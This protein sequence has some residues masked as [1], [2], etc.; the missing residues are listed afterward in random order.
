MQYTSDKFK[1]HYL[2]RYTLLIK[3]GDVHDVL[4][5]LDDQQ[6]ILRAQIYE[7][8]QPPASVTK[9]LSLPFSKVYLSMSHEAYDEAH[10]SQYSKYLQQEDRV[11][12]YTTR[13]SALSLTAI[14]QYDILKLNKWK[15]FF[16]DVHIVPEFAVWLEQ[17]QPNIPIKGKVLGLHFND[18]R[19]DVF[20]F[21]NGNFI[22]YNHFEVIN[23]QDVMFYFLQV[24]QNF[25]LENRVDKILCSGISTD[26][27]Y[28][29]AL[30]PYA[31]HIEFIRHFNP[32]SASDLAVMEKLFSH[33][34]LL[35][36]PL[37]AL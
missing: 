34:I 26:H 5:V 24:L 12:Y 25:D 8:E 19:M 36:T 30:Q 10:A 27:A 14:Y 31:D 6:E 11:A 13:L 35:D 9:M 23:R 2:S 16:P 15:S 17:A 22:L 1:L 20:L 4:L 7:G 3:V 33:N 32:V 18:Q 28:L 29:T 21:V 37:C